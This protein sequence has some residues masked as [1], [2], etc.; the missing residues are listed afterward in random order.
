MLPHL[1]RN[2]LRRLGRPVEK[3]NE[4]R[5]SGGRSEG[6]VGD[7]HPRRSTEIR[8][9]PRREVGLLL[10]EITMTGRDHIPS[11]LQRQ[12]MLEVGYRCPLCHQT[13]PLEF[14]HIEEYADVK[15]HEFTNMIVLC[16]S[17]H[18]RKKN[19]SSPRHINRASLKKLKQSL[20][21]L[22]GRYSDLERRVLEV[23]QKFLKANPDVALPLTYILPDTMHLLVKRLEDD[24]L[25]E[26]QKRDL[27][28]HTT[29][30]DGLEVK[31]GIII[32]VLT[33]TGKEF[34]ANL[35]AVTAV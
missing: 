12:L 19:T 3:S 1:G 30:G 21:L 35:I 5:P 8:R 18:G 17:C 33:P 9:K 26:I 24:G 27:G 32:L 2:R 25:V 4:G 6:S 31:N 11:E 20:M 34:V 15:K 7:C 29:F 10:V 23:F 14:E 28:F 13:E 22:N 16:A